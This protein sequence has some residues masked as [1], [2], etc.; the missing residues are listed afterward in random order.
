MTFLLLVSTTGLRLVP[1]G[2][3]VPLRSDFESFPSQVGNWSGTDL[4]DRD[5]KTKDVLR[6]DNYLLRRYS[7]RVTGAHADLFIVY[8]KSQESDDTIHSPKNCW[9]GGGWEPVLSDVEKVPDPAI[10]EGSFPAN[11]Y[12]I[13]KDGVRQDALYWYQALSLAKTLAGR[14]ISNL[15]L[16]PSTALV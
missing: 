12:V 9:P 7:N 5:P 10:P 6:A 2:H 16:C 13:E 15:L 4:P 3:P 11:H 14:R 1:R 8:Y